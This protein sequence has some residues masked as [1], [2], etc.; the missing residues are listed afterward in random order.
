MVLP[1]YALASV[2]ESSGCSTSSSTPGVVACM[3]FLGCDIRNT[4]V[5]HSFSLYLLD[6]NF[7]HFFIVRIGHSYVFLCGVPPQSFVGLPL[8]L[9]KI[10]R[11]F[12]FFII[13][14]K[15]VVLETSPFLDICVVNI[16]SQFTVCLFIF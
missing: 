1:S 16:F 6:D 5:S 10:T 13:G 14:S 3:C 4:A 8:P 15:R 7:E 2:Y 12:C 9:F 11:L